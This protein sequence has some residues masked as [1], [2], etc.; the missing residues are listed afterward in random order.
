MMVFTLNDIMQ[1]KLFF[2]LSLYVMMMDFDRVMYIAATP[3]A[4]I[5]N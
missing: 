3:L 5:F 2:F 1:L 4:I